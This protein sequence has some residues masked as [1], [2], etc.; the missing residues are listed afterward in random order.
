MPQLTSIRPTPRETWIVLA[1]AGGIHDRAG[2]ARRHHPS[3]AH[4]SP[5]N[6]SNSDGGQSCN[7]D[8]QKPGGGGPLLGSDDVG[9]LVELWAEYR[10][11]REA[12]VMLAAAETYDSPS[13][14]L[15][16]QSICSFSEL[17]RRKTCKVADAGFSH[18]PSFAGLPGNRAARPGLRGKLAWDQR[19]LPAV[20]GMVRSS[21]SRRS[22][23]R[24][25]S[26][27]A[28]FPFVTVKAMTENTR[29]GGATTAPAAPLTSAALTNG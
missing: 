29:P 20:G 11:H 18:L 25:T 26:I 2:H 14:R 24:R 27:W 22:G 21:C 17:T 23:S 6:R 4:S 3:T 28:I 7:P 15:A 16:T 13:A 19:C 12:G 1:L 5:S 8:D 9:G 10:R